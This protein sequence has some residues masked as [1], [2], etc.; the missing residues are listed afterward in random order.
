MAEQIVKKVSVPLTAEDAG[1]LQEMCEDSPFPESILLKLAL[2]IGLQ[3]I[4]K[5][6]T[7]LMPFVA[8]PT[9]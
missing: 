2:R 9:E 1:T 4:R 7:V 5:D 3:A 6:P 8:K